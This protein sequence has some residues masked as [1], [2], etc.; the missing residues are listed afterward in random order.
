MAVGQPRFRQICAGRILFDLADGCQL[1]L[2]LGQRGLKSL[3]AHRTGRSLRQYIF[4]LQIER[5]P[6]TFAGST[7]LRSYLPLVVIHRAGA[8]EGICHLFL[9][10][11]TFPTS[12]HIFILRRFDMIDPTIWVRYLINQ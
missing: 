5:L 11:F 2:N 12:G 9:H 3:A 4:A 10:R 7:F 8:I 6:V 1:R